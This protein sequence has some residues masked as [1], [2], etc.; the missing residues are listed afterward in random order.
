M[1]TLVYMR[2]A[3]V[4][5]NK[6]IVILHREDPETFTFGVLA[7]FLGLKRNVAHKVYHRD[8]DLYSKK[9]VPQENL[10]K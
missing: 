4:L 8:K 6:A 9:S 7:K 5:R 2:Q 10:S 1:V 3:N